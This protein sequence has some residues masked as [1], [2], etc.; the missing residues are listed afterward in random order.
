MEQK[1]PFS[2]YLPHLVILG[3]ILVVSCFFCLPA[4]QGNYMNQ[5]DMF[6]WLQG[7]QESR[8]FYAATG[9]EAAWANNMFS[10]M[11]QVL[12]DYY[13][14]TNWY[15]KLN[16]IIQMYSTGVPH[17]P[18]I[19]FIIAMVSF[20]LLSVALKWNRWLGLIGAIAF[21]FSTYN[22]I[23]ISA[24]HT[25]KM[26]DIA[27]MPA[28]LAGVIWALR[29]NYLGGAAFT[30]VVLAM[31]IDSGHFQII[32]YLGLV[33]IVGLL[34]AGY[35]FY[36]AG[37][38]KQWFISCMCLAM[39]AVFSAMA[40]TEH[41][42]ETQAFSKH[43]IRGGQS[44]LADTKNNKE[45]GLDKE[46]AFSWSNGIEETMNLLVPGLFGGAS[47][48]QLSENS[49]FAEKLTALRVPYNQVESMIDNAPTYWGPQPM[50]SGPVYFGATICFLFVLSFLLVKSSKKWWVLGVVVFFVVL[51]TGKHM[52]TI[53]YFLFDNFPGLNKFRAPS[54]AL[55]IPA[56][57]FPIMAMWALKEVYYSNMEKVEVFKKVKVALYAVGG[58][59]VLTLIYTQTGFSY[60]SPSDQQ[61]IVGRFGQYGEDVLRAIKD[62][63][64][65]M[66]FSDTL[67]SLVLVILIAVV[68]MSYSKDKLSKTV[69]VAAVG[70]LISFDVLGVAH[71]Y[72]NKKHFITQDEWHQ[73]MAQR[74]VDRQI[75]QDKDLY[76]RVFD[77]TKSPFNDAFPSLFHSSIGGYHGAKLQ[78]YQDLIENQIGKFNSGVLNMLNAKYFIVP[79]G[80]NGAEVVQQNPGALGNAWFVNEI[81]FVNTAREEMDALNA[82]SLQNPMDTSMGMFDP[83]K[84][85]IIRNDLKA[86]VTVANPVKDPSAT[87]QLVKYFPNKL[88]FESN[89]SGNGFG[90]F[91]DIYYGEG[92]TA[93]ID[94]QP[95][96]IIR[97]D[98]VLRG[99]NIPAGKHVIEFSFELPDSKKWSTVALIGSI[100]I[101]ILVV[102]GIYSSVRKQKNK[103]EVVK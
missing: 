6:T 60:Q 29:G 69:A 40:N 17:N 50:I 10:G 21:A 88:V 4:F 14:E 34:V 31:F 71:R 47:N 87:I 102:A 75:K 33:I 52:P 64:A 97:T 65:A 8:D 15:H 42:M 59:L 53:N 25:T 37:K 54:M 90:V 84:T 99:L 38:V 23:I 32:Y 81:K 45:T 36:K 100:C 2:K 18:A 95:T 16:V 63:R 35:Y 72:L 98:Y 70:V 30:A 66:A 3:I 43:T 82:P 78:I 57:F 1:G 83:A 5:H 44:E 101:T 94:G 39:A 77:I 28:V 61:N 22:P 46:Y 62:D 103:N 26:V 11:P 24:G 41:F 55:V 92:W 68:L 93:T 91:S 73:E 89:N 79:G 74:P 48:E 27:Y 85:A 76:Y 67:R 9:E 80:P 49:N 51:S 58:L 56:L 86:K 13:P 96:D 12:T 7:S 20:Y 19:F